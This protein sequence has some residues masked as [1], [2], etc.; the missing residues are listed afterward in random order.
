MNTATAK[1][2]EKLEDRLLEVKE[3]GMKKVEKLADS[4]EVAMLEA[5][6]A[7]RKARYA[8]EDS[9]DRGRQQIKQFP[10]TAVALGALAGLTLG[11]FGT[12]LASKKNACRE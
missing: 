11:I 7:V 4:V 5:N 10:F 8:A 9:L 12:I 3:V 2:S 6:R 1:V